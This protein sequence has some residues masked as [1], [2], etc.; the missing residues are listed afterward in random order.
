MLCSLSDCAS[1]DVKTILPSI[2]ML[3]KYQNVRRMHFDAQR[4]LMENGE[5]RTLDDI[6]NTLAY[7][8]S[9]ARQSF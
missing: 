6:Q 2:A 9:E 5:K 1:E 7:E 4:C 3:F 8:T